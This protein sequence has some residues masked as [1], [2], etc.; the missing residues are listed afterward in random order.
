MS[1][2]KQLMTAS[3]LAFTAVVVAPVVLEAPAQAQNVSQAVGNAL[4]EAQRA[5]SFNAA[6]AAIDRAKGAAASDAERRIVGQL[7]ANVYARLRAF[8][9]AAAELEAVGGPATSLAQLH[10]S[11][12]NYAKAIQFANRAGGNGQMGVLIAQS[13]LKTGNMGEA[14]KAYQRLVNA[15]FDVQ[16]NLTNLAS[17]QFRTGDR[18]GYVQTLERL[19]KIDPSPENWKRVLAGLQGQRMPDPAKLGLYMLMIETGNLT[20]TDD[21]A[22][23]AKLSMVTGAPGLARSA[24]QSA[25]SGGNTAPT[26][27]G[28]LNTANQRVTAANQALPQLSRSATGADLL[29]A[30]RTLLGN[31]QF[32]EAAAMYQRAGAAGGDPGEATLMQGVAQLKAGDTAGGRA[33]LAKV[34]QGV[35]SDI[36]ALWRL[37]SQTR[38]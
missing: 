3:V 33:T 20:K 13:H 18:A 31:G 9:P 27:P 19:I 1:V 4:K 24:L 25:I 12:G 21:I 28:L 6:K 11:A 16:D 30:G 8:G 26:L 35:F 23:L 15:G 29:R 5:T 17:I 34:P 32:R 22:D 14:A 36:G 38:G 10:Y 7:A 2:V 37:Y